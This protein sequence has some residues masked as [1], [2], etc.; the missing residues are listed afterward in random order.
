MPEEGMN[1][2]DE[3]ICSKCNWKHENCGTSKDMAICVEIEKL[4]AEIRKAD[5]LDSIMNRLDA[6]T[7]EDGMLTINTKRVN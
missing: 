5:A 1:W 7:L 6:S 2:F 4:R 3:N